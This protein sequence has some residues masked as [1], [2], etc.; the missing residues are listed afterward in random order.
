[1]DPAT[2]YLN[3]STAQSVYEAAL[4]A[5]STIIQPSLLDFLR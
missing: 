3:L 4:K 2:A 1:V 5:G